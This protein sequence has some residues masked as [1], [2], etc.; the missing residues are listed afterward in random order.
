[1]LWEKSPHYGCGFS[2]WTGPLYKNPVPEF[3]MDEFGIELELHGDGE[4][5]K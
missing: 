1:L 4:R 3:Q 5:E 2:G